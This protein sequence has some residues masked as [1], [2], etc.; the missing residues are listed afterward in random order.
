M[1]KIRE[2][3]TEIR[4]RSSTLIIKAGENYLPP[5]EIDMPPNQQLN[6]VSYDPDSGGGRFQVFGSNG[7]FRDS[8]SIAEFE[9]NVSELR[10]EWTFS[11]FPYLKKYGFP[12]GIMLVGPLSRSLQP[13]GMLDDQEILNF[14]LASRIDRTNPTLESYDTCRLLEIFWNANKILNFLEEIDPQDLN[15][16]VDFDVSGRG[17]GVLEAPRGILVHSY[18]INRGCIERVNMLVATQFNNPFINLLI[19]NMAEN[20]LEGDGISEQGDAMIGRCIRIF[21]PCLSCA[22]H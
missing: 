19:Q 10:A 5:Q 11:K 20:Y 8:F 2:L 13:G 18:L 3:A 15:V 7:E 12:S 6:F 16:E 21:D 1:L 14:E 9:E 17:I 4:Q 22:T